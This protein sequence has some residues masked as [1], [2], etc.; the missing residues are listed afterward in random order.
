MVKGGAWIQIQLLFWVWSI[1]QTLL[2]YK[3]VCVFFFFFWRF[4][5]ILALRREFHSLPNGWLHATFNVFCEILDFSPELDK[6]RA[7]IP[8][9]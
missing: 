3:C 1:K 8:Q 4:G 6:L 2:L 9:L 5:I 7:L